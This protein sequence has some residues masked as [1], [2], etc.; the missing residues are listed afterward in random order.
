[1]DRNREIVLKLA[2]LRTAAV[3]AFALGLASCAQKPKPVPPPPSY[4]QFMQQA[5]ARVQAQDVDGAK[6]L[7]KKAAVADPTKK[8]P[9]YAL[10]QLEFDQQSYGKAIVDSQEVLQR[11]PTDMNAQNI[12]TVAGLRVAVEALGRLHDES[13][14]QGPAHLEAVKLA[15]KMRETLGQDV[16]VPP[17]KKPVRKTRRVH[18]PDAAQTSPAQS[19]GTPSAT[20]STKPAG[21]DPFSTLKDNSH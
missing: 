9:W 4:D 8:A 21:N 12:L 20:P 17:V 2:Y 13:N 11:D 18:N 10:A 3:L 14:I 7:F 6:S 15:D 5:Q 19:N 1:M 16:L